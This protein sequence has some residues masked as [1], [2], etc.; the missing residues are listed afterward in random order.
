M[1]KTDIIRTL[2]Y[3]LTDDSIKFWVEV[4]IVKNT[5]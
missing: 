2:L 3:Y 5:Y 1:D 4:I